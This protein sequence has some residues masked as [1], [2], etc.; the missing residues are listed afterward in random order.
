MI[1]IKHV[2]KIDYAQVERLLAIPKFSTPLT[3]YLGVVHDEKKH[4]CLY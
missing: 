4:V 2:V 3:F 1:N